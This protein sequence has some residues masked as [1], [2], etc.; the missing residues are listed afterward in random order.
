MLPMMLGINNPLA[1]IEMEIPL[2]GYAEGKPTLSVYTYDLAANEVYDENKEYDVVRLL[3]L[4]LCD[5]EEYTYN[6][7]MKLLQP[8]TT[9]PLRFA[10]L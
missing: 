4:S 8:L 10:N 5:G 2:T 7:D 1:A 6:L 3:A 9:I